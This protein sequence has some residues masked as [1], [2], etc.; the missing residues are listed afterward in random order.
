MPQPV[1]ATAGFFFIVLVAFIVVY[2][3]VKAFSDGKSRRQ[4]AAAPPPSPMDAL[5]QLRARYEEIYRAVNVPNSAAI[6][7]VVTNS[8]MPSGA[9]ARHYC[10]VE[11]D[12]LRMFPLWEGIAAAANATGAADITPREW[13]IPV[14]DI[15]CFAV[16]QGLPSKFVV[17]QFKMD[18]EI[19]TLS[20]GEE[21]AR[22]FGA[23]IPQKDFSHLIEEL[24][25]KSSRN[26]YDI[27]ESFQSLKELREEDLI[28][29]DEYAA[30]KKEML[31][32]M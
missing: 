23:I 25:P 19:L 4:P 13:K 1:L 30:K 22:I 3:A 15:I 16:E 27:R 31:I 28:T 10:W 9:A 5:S 32:L 24:Y 21:A 18:S 17:L 20:F 14:P 12:V 8:Y 2:F 11:G 6:V 26:I 29:E 7:R